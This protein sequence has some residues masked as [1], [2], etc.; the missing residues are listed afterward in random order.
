MVAIGV[1]LVGNGVVVT[2]R[3]DVKGAVFKRRVVQGDPH[4][5]P[6]GGIL[7]FKVGVVLVPGSTLSLSGRFQENLIQIK[8]ER[9]SDQAPNG[10]DHF[11]VKGEGAVESAFGS[12]GTN[13]QIYFGRRMGFP[14]AF[15]KHISQESFALESVEL[16]T[17]GINLPFLKHVG[18]DAKT[19]FSKLLP[20]CKRNDHR[21][22]HAICLRGAKKAKQ[23]CLFCL[24]KNQTRRFGGKPEYFPAR[25]TFYNTLK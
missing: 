12:D 14:I 2:A 21:L 16:C 6:F 19:F 1:S 25:G 7:Y 17:H 5:N 15:G 11:G 18:N 13:L 24:K 9:V 20:L 23:K 22:P 3:H 4:A 8:D 10:H